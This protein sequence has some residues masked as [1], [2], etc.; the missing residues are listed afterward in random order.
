MFIL[1]HRVAYLMK[2]LEQHSLGVN[3][4]NRTWL[5][6]YLFGG[7]IWNSIVWKEKHLRTCLAMFCF[8]LIYIRGDNFILQWRHGWGNVDPS[9]SFDTWWWIVSIKAQAWFDENLIL[10]YVYILFVAM[11]FFVNDLCVF[12]FNLQ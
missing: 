12:P 5:C 8:F 6:S 3:W 10:R 9:N 2:L 7:I 4:F 1:R 11:V